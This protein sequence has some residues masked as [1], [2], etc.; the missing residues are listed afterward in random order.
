[1]NKLVKRRPGQKGLSDQ[2]GYVIIGHLNDGYHVLLA[3]LGKEPGTDKPIFDIHLYEQ[4]DPKGTFLQRWTDAAATGNPMEEDFR[5]SLKLLSQLKPAFIRCKKGIKEVFSYIS[6][7]TVIGHGNFEE[8]NPLYTMKLRPDIVKLI[9]KDILMESIPG[10]IRT[11][12]KDGDS[13]SWM[14]IERRD[15]EE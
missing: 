9:V 11:P 3:H 5:K 2:D 4:S 8:M 1:M 7:R 15:P 13:F 12:G 6:D 10:L 14:T